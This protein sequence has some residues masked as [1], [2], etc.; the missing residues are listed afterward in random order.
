MPAA[1]RSDKVRFSIRVKAS[2][3]KILRWI[4]LAREMDGK[5]YQAPAITAAIGT[6]VRTRQYIH[7][8]SV[9]PDKCTLDKDQFFSIKLDENIADMIAALGLGHSSS[10]F[11]LTII[12]STIEEDSE[13]SL[14]DLFDIQSEALSMIASTPVISVKQQS[15]AKK[16]QKPAKRRSEAS[17]ASDD[18][19]R[20]PIA[21][22]ASEAAAAAPAQDN[23]PSLAKSSKRD[24]LLNDLVFGKGSGMGN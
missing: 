21:K 24:Q 12:N 11:F 18:K 16:P 6:F 4:E 17:S 19:I 1:S 10:E 9:D 8:G 22:T 2:N 15:K 14:P 3:K 13:E 7:L 23:K 20:E 5:N